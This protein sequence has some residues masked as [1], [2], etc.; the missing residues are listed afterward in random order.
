MVTVRSEMGERTVTW[1]VASME[2]ARIARSAPGRR[3]R[4]RIRCTSNPDKTPSD[5]G[6]IFGFE[7]MASLDC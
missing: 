1:F 6:E 3:W 2:L 7:I 4:T 5:V